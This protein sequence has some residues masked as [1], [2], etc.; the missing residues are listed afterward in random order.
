MPKV[1]V[2]GPRAA[3]LP[4]RAVGLEILPADTSEAAKTQLHK[5]Y[6][7][8]NSELLI[9]LPEEW[10]P[11]CANEVAHLRQTPTIAIMAMPSLTGQAGSQ[12]SRVRALVTRSLGVDLMNKE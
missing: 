1:V 10:M 6:G 8:N 2:I 3:M 5:L 7:E 12:L 11:D 9:L 4:F